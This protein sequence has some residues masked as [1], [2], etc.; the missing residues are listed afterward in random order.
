MWGARGS[1]EEAAVVVGRVESEARAGRKTRACRS[2]GRRV[3]RIRGW[4]MK[5][6]FNE[7]GGGAGEMSANRE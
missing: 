2:M 7:D 1:A 6:F 3:V 4:S 5:D